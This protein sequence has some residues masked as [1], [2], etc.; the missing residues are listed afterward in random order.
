MADLQSSIAPR[1]G[2]VLAGFDMAAHV[3][4]IKARDKA[5]T[6]VLTVI[7]GLVLTMLAAIVGYVLVSG[8]GKLFD[9]GF[10]T[11]KPEQF[12]AGGGIGPE[13]FNS[14]YLLVLTLL[15][16]VPLSL[17][18]AIFLAEYAPDNAATRIAKTLIETLSSLPSIVVG[19]FG[20]LFF[21]LQMGWGF[22]IIAGAVALTMFNVPILVRVIQQALEDVP[23]TQRDAALAMGLTRW[24][25]TVHV[26]LPVAMPAIVTGVV[27]SAGRVFGEAAA[28]IFTAGQSAPMLD[29][30]N[31][32][33]SSP[34]CPWNVFRPAETLAVHIWKI[35]SEGVVPDLE[36]VSN[37]TAAV[38]LACILLFNVLARLIGKFLERR[39]TSE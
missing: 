8:A 12:K 35:N 5:A 13:L 4:R 21:V 27:L 32:D 6:V 38:L 11:G 39:L 14:F 36:A 3:R 29:F 7:V 26:L 22:S 30:T 20:F 23:R 15:I 31:F 16:S 10:L 25:T 28:L 37:G 1:E 19:L 2:G 9:I 34:T 24:E 17:G 33:L 18:A